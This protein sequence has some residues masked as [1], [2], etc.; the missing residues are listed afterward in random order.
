M[1]LK[2][3]LPLFIGQ[4]M[5]DDILANG[6]RF[7][8]TPARRGV[9]PRRVP[10]RRLPLRAQHDA[11]L[12]PGQPRGRQRRTPFFGMIFDSRRRGQLR[13]GRP[14]RRRSGAP[15]RFIG[16]QTFFDFGDGQVKP[17]KR[18]DTKLS[19]PLFNL[20]LAAIPAGDP[21]HFA[22]AAHPPPAPDLVA[23]VRSGDRR[24]IWAPRC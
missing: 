13:P 23:A 16:W 10:G 15:R 21:A 19:T 11:S 1:I 2:E 18:I 17:N 12:V 20:P 9:Y 22:L 24:T 3:F 7:Y 5:V 6:R 4:A 8:Y 14:A